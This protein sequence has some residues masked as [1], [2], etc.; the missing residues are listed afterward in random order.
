M[1][2]LYDN[3]RPIATL[4]LDRHPDPEF[5]ASEAVKTGTSKLVDDAL[6]VHRMAVRRDLAGRR[7]GVLLLD[8][9]CDRAHRTGYRRLLL[10]VARNAQPLQR[11]YAK[12]GFHH[13]VTVTSTGR[14]SGS[15]WERLAKP[16][17]MSGRTL[18]N[19][20]NTQVLLIGND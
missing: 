11:Y 17:A 14:K 16:S 2:L 19:R 15:P 1:W 4:A 20:P 9:A 18:R 7:T 3:S 8:W 5:T 13:L 6:I 12:A 10:N